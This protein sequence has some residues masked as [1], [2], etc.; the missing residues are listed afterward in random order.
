VLTMRAMLAMLRGRIDDAVLLAT[1]AA[2]IH[3]G[4]GD[5]G[6][7]VLLS[8]SVHGLSLMLDNRDLVQAVKIVEE[9]WQIADSFGGRWARSYADHHLSGI[10]LAQGDVDGA[11]ELALRCLETKWRLHDT[12]GT[13]LALDM[14][15]RI[16]MERSDGRAAARLLGLAQQVW[17]GHGQEAVGMGSQQL[18]SPREQC[19]SAA[20]ALLGADVYQELYLVG[21]SLDV[22]EA[23][24]GLLIPK[25]GLA[26]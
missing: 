12:L 5:T 20:R 19:E 4:L 22:A 8:L 25:A 1:D 3:R 23:I 13:A 14:L 24:G 7:G 11:E 2:E 18:S 26:D 9:M 10:R 21:R 17:S 15:A 16:A 6:F